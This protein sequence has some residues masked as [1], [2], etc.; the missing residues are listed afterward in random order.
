MG[1]VD[2]E[3]QE[4]QRKSNESA[5]KPSE[6]TEGS[7]ERRKW[8][9]LVRGLERDVKEFRQVGGTAEFTLEENLAC[10]VANPKAQ[11]AVVLTGDLDAHAIRY[12]YEPE[13]GQTAVPEGGLL[14]L[15]TTTAGVE[16]YSADQR[17]SSEEA[18]R[19]ILEPLMFP[20]ASLA[21]LEPTGT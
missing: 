18:R 8:D 14:S 10:R 17:L 1:W 3:F 21:G 2:D 6:R 19:L 15:R 7:L 13:N 11:V 4:R 9:E 20:R 5:E 16:F 12:H